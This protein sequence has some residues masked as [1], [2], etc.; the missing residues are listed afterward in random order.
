MEQIEFIKQNKLL[1]TITNRKYISIF[2]ASLVLIAI[3][4]TIVSLINTSGEFSSTGDESVRLDVFKLYFVLLMIIGVG[5]V[6]ILICMKKKLEYIYLTA[7]AFLGITYMFSI[8]PLSVPDEYHHY[9]TTYVISSYM[10]F[11]DDPYT[12]DGNHF[13]YRE[14]A[15]HY[16]VPSAYLRLMDEGPMYKNE[17]AGTHEIQMR[18][19]DTYAFDYPLIYLP[20]AIGVIFARLLGMGFFGVYYIGALFNLA[21]YIFCV[22]FSIKIL[23]TFKLP[24]FMLGLLPMTLQQASSFSPDGFVNGVSI[25]LIAYAISCIY[26]NS[27]FRWRDCIVLLVLSLLLTPA[28]VAYFPIV[29]LIVLVAV[30]WREE[31][32]AKAWIIAGGIIALSVSALVFLMGTTAMEIATEPTLNWEGGYNYTLSFILENPLET[33]KIFLRSAYHMREW[34][35]YST[36]GISLSGLTLD[37]PQWHIYIMIFLLLAGIIYGKKDEWQPVWWHRLVYLSIFA[38]VILLN[39]TAMFLGWTSDW[40]PVIIGIQGRYFIP[41]M[42]LLLLLLK[43]RFTQI[44]KQLFHDCAVTG[45]V[46]IQCVSVMFVLNYTI[47]LF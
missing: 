35:I 27:S 13:D 44:S 45:F 43:N 12:A 41:A 10:M 39:M 5:L 17:D 24:F 16:N 9:P 25:L 33:I 2:I 34:Y 40:H 26:E 29:F 15:G 6:C 46:A 14:L 23:N 1:K 36:F 18:D 21:F 38:A 30:K 20:Q 7:A 8:T 11:K 37:L 31:I 32:K 4:I 22:T 42:P 28:K 3:I 47:C 19:T